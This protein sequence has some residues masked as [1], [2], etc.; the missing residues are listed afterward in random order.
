GRRERCPAV[1]AELRKRRRAMRI[2]LLV[3]VLAGA[4]GCAA[5]AMAQTDPMEASIAVSRVEVR[6]G[7]TT[8]FYATGEL[9]QG[10]KVIVVR[11]SKEPGWLEIKPPTGSFSWVNTKHVTQVNAYAAVVKNDAPALIGSALIS[12]KPT[13]ESKPG[14]L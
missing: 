4:L 3:G 1:R 12:A 2:R 10:E 5:P 13:A 7:P 6:S 8:K 9:H 14:F 11:E